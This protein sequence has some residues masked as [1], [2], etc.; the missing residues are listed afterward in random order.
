MIET[1]RSKVKEL[2]QTK[3]IECFIG[4]ERS[5]DG[6]TARP[7]F[8][9]EPEEAER[10]IFDSTCIH[11]LT[12]YL[13]DRRDKATGILV[14]ACDS[15]AINLL[16]QEKQIKREKVYIIGVICNGVY[17]VSWGKVNQNIAPRCQYCS[18]HTPVIYDFLVGEPPEEEQVAPYPELENMEAKPLEERKVFWRE[19]FRRCIR[20]YA[21]RQV[22]PGCYC[23]Q[24]FV[25]QLEPLW[26]GIRIDLWA[27]QV[28]NIGRAIHLAGRC[29][30]C[31]ECQRV[32]PLNIPLMLLNQRLSQEVK[33]LF[34]FEPG[35]DP[36]IPP[37]FAT[38]TK[39]EEI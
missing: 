9:Y 11:N 22:C 27:N 33:K 12:R 10:L 32:C 24:C 6:L 30:Q 20:C 5:T 2:L 26:V 13:L 8:A 28:W 16:L 29:I 15:K 36:Q 34:D 35:L 4:Y 14:K 25:E 39:E 18:R 1:I 17:Q 21:C 19:Q 3:Q 31:G 37:P 38:Y 23:P 7:L